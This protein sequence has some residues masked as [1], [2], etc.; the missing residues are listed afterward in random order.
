MSAYS[1][2]SYTGD[3]SAQPPGAPAAPKPL[4]SGVATIETFTVREPDG[5]R[6]G[7]KLHEFVI[8]DDGFGHFRVVNGTADAAWYGSLADA[9]AD[10]LASCGD[11]A[12][13]YTDDAA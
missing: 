6:G 5:K 1:N 2:G 4:F 9:Q 3:T 10:A 13:A 7:F 8:Q 12:A 11:G